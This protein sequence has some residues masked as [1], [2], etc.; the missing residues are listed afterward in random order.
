MKFVKY[1][2]E[3][4]A[5]K[6]LILAEDF[7][8]SS[9]SLVKDELDKFYNSLEKKIA[10][11]DI[12]GATKELEELEADLASLEAENA[13]KKFFKFPQFMIDGQKKR[14]AAYRAKL[15]KNESIDDMDNRCQK[16]N[17]LLNDMGTCPKCDDGEE[18]Y[19]DE[20][21]EALYDANKS[22]KSIT[23]NP[24]M[25]TEIAQIAQRALKLNDYEAETLEHDIN[26]LRANEWVEDFAEL[27]DSASAKQLFFTHAV[28]PEEKFEESLT[29]R[30]MSVR[31]K[32]KNAYPELNFDTPIHESAVCQE[33][34]SNREKL[35]KAYPELNFDTV[36]SEEI[37]TEALSNKEKLIQAYPGVF[38]FESSDM[39]E[40]YEEFDDEYDFD[41]DVEMDRRHAALYGGDRTY[42]DCGKKLV[43]TDWG[44]YCP[45]CEPDT[46]EEEHLRMIDDEVDSDFI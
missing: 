17:T 45:D 31:E 9:N 1:T 15:T 35:K 6:K 38:S 18:D 32:L 20:L 26:N 19:G 21:K 24:E 29:E 5:A 28:T 7:G 2:N 44:S 33:E 12:E 34:L 39:T 43:M 11:G 22:Y 4:V 27:P 36:V 30:T 46:A 16:C 37:Q 13:K 10:S 14:L 8:D 42:C 41:D 25:A 40:E 23:T 3:S